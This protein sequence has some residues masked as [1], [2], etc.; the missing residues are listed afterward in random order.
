MLYEVITQELGFL[1][2]P[3]HIRDNLD[4]APNQYRIILMGVSSGEAEVYHDREMAI[5]PGQVFGSLQGIETKD[6]AFGLDA[7]WIGRDQV[8]Q[9][10][11][12]GYTRNNFV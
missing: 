5:N 3:V 6:P 4:L 9:A 2:P 10:H 12:L 11:S 8:D 1:I 7:I